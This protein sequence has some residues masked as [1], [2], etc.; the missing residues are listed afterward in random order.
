MLTNADM[1][2]YATRIALFLKSEGLNHED[3]VGI[4]AN[5]STYV[6]PVA[7]GCFFNATPFHAVNYS[8]EP[9]IVKGLFSVTKPK[10]MFI[11]APDYER[12][13]EITKEWSPKIITLT[14]RVEGLTSVEDLLKPHPAER[15]Y[16]S[17]QEL[18]LYNGYFNSLYCSGQ[19]PW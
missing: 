1:L 9:A 7:T 13:K 5:S 10:I 14:G 12:I 6:I 16:V 17:V 8:R 15:I 2:A 4:I 19:L 3:K 11:D 18:S